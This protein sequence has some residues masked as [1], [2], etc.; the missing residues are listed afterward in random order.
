LNHEL[1]TVKF[2]FTPLA[3]VFYCLTL[4]VVKRSYDRINAYLIRKKIISEK[5]SGKDYTFV[6]TNTSWSDDEW[7]KKRA[8]KP[9]SFDYVITTLLWFIPTLLA[10]VV[11][12]I[13][14]T[15]TAG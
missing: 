8:L 5:F 15:N 9:S 1:P 4:V 3:L 13:F 6:V 14:D 7:D 2:R 10:V 11:I 12:H